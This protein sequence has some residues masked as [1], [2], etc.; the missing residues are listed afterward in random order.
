MS[1][2]KRNSKDT[3]CNDGKVNIYF[4]LML[5]V[6]GKLLIGCGFSLLILNLFISLSTLEM[7]KFVGSRYFFYL[8]ELNIFGFDENFFFW[9]FPL[10]VGG[11]GVVL[12]FIKVGGNVRWNEP[13]N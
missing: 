10:L 3:D 8:A 2:S 9:V 11:I 7:M 1:V 4:T 5:N 12:Y 6:I 13:W